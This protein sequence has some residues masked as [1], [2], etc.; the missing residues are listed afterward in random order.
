MN[1]V[2]DASTVVAAL[3]DTGPDGQWAEQIIKDSAVFAPSLLHVECTNVLRRLKTSR[4]LNDLNASIAHKNLMLLDVVLFPFEPFAERIWS[5]RENI[6][7]YDAWYVAVAEEL[8]IP[9]ATLDTKLTNAP[10]LN[11]QFISPVV[12]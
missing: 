11:C 2:V 4:Q 1:I 8:E 12:A 10:G 3:V 9:L 5:L 7:S 6:S